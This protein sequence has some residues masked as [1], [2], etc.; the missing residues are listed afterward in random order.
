MLMSEIIN[1]QII[2]TFHGKLVDLLSRAPL[3]LSSIDSLLLSLLF[4]F[5]LRVITTTIRTTINPDIAQITAMSHGCIP[6]TLSSVL[7]SRVIVPLEPIGR[8]K[9]I[10]SLS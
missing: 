10:F 6:F 1:S 5:F 2:L 9:P 8:A 3:V 7:V 4:F